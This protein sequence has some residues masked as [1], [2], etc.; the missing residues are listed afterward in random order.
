MSELSGPEADMADNMKAAENSGKLSPAARDLQTWQMWGMKPQFYERR[1]QRPVVGGPGPSLL[2]PSAEPMPPGGMKDG[3]DIWYEPPVL[4]RPGGSRFWIIRHDDYRDDGATGV[5]LEEF[6]SDLDLDNLGSSA[7]IPRFVS[8]RK[9]PK[10]FTEFFSGR[11][12]Y[13]VSERLLNV[14]RE[15]DEEAITWIRQERIYAGGEEGPQ[16]FYFIN[17]KRQLPVVDFANSGVRYEK[18]HKDYPVQHFNFRAARLLPNIPARCHIIKEGTRW[19]GPVFIST[20][21]KTALE[22]LKPK[23]YQVRFDDPGHPHFT[24]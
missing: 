10:H 21:L 15:F 6:E 9:P 12:I 18:K 7:I 3:D 4:P 1:F 19:L 2:P 11:G 17:V 16:I 22:A 24:F 13:T 8:K 20:E 23:P 5:N 14:M